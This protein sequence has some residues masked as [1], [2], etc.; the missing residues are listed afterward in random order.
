M[1]D[2]NI[3]SLNVRGL[4]N[5]KKRREIFHWLKHY[6]NG[7]NNIIFLQETH[8]IDNDICW[9]KEWG[10]KVL[11]S[12]GSSNSRGV[13]TMI[14]KNY[15]FTITSKETDNSGRILVLNILSEDTEY[16]LINIYA[17]TSDHEIEQMNFYNNLENIVETNTGKKSLL[18]EI[19]I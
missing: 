12:N 9:E 4:R 19:L 14:Q 11:M 3:L 17:P 15:N 8:S 18:V 1:L 10:S 7:S 6:H 5:G 16:C 13:V 2:H